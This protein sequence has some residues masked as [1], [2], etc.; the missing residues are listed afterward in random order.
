MY[1]DVTGRIDGDEEL[2]VDVLFEQP[3][4]ITTF[5]DEFD[6]DDDNSCWCSLFGTFIIYGTSFL[7]LS[8][9]LSLEH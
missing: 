7:S 4:I 3:I 2:V 9:F 8:L 1:D 5:D 6:S